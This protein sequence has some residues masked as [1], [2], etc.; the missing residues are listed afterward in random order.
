MLISFRLPILVVT[1]VDFEAFTNNG[2]KTSST[3]SN[4]LNAGILSTRTGVTNATI[5][6]Y[7]LEWLKDVCFLHSHVNGT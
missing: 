1:D 3:Q 7:V 5:F 2:A 4:M 6:D